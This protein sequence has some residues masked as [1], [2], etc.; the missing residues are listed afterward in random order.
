MGYLNA[1]MGSDNR[2]YEEVM[3]QHAFGENSENG[4]KFADTG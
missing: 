3:E 2:G 1:K 4:E